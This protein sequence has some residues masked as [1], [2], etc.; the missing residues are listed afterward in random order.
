MNICLKYTNKKRN[1][2]KLNIKKCGEYGGILKKIEQ[3]KN[4]YLKGLLVRPVE[5]K[6]M[7]QRT[8]PNKV[9]ELNK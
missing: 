2:I 8:L 3:K 5:R 1:N 9:Y 4:Q 6:C 7:N